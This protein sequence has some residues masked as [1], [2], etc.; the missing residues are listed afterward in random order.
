MFDKIKDA[1]FKIKD[2]DRLERDY[3]IL[4]CHVTDGLLSKTNYEINGLL[5]VIGDINT[6]NYK[7]AETETR[8]EIMSL[9]NSRILELTEDG[10]PNVTADELRAL[11]EKILKKFENE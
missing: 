6:K 2:Y 3:S 10:R 7:E 4:L 5:T 9:I 8:N 1:I 11:N